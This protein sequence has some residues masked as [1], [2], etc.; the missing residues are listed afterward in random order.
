MEKCGRVLDTIALNILCIFCLYVLNKLTS[1]LTIYNQS[2]TVDF[3]KWMQTTSS[4]I[5]D[6]NFFDNNIIILSS[7]SPILNDLWDRDVFVRAHCHPIC[8]E[9]KGSSNLRFCI[10]EIF[11]INYLRKRG[12]PNWCYFVFYKHRQNIPSSLC[13]LWSGASCC[14]DVFSGSRTNPT[15]NL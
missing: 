13:T 8:L 1:L 9:W 4:T 2:H 3:E 12:I 7:I 14:R 11:V 15:Q 5:I 10:L 6:N